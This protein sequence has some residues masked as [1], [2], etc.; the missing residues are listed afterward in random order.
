VAVVAVGVDGK[1]VVVTTEA[2]ATV[3]REDI[4]AKAQRAEINVSV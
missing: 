4:H 3:T 2:A 1:N